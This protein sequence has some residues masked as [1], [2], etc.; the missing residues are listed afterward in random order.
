MNRKKGFTL[1]ELLVVIA[2]IGILASVVL[3]S[4]NSARK[5]SRDARRIADVKQLQLAL[6]LYFDGQTSAS[7]PPGTIITG[8]LNPSY[9]PVFPTAPSPGSYSYQALNNDS[10]AC[11]A[12]PCLSYVLR[13][14]LEEGTNIALSSDIDGTVVLDCTDTPTFYY[15]MRP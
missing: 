12:A 15:C 13:A 8:V 1:I 4:L 3:A 14:Q 11:A 9:I 2:I 6:E 7:Y 10:T 5:K